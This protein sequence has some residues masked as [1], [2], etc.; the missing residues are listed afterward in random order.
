MYNRADNGLAFSVPLTKDEWSAFTPPKLAVGERWALL[1]TT[2]RQFAAVLSPYA[3]TRFRPRPADATV[4]ELRGEVEAA[5]DRQ[6]RI[7]LTGR[8]QVDW[9]HDGNEHSMGA[10]TAEGC[11]FL[12]F[13]KPGR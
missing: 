10:A 4:A 5:D 7:R 6:A 9:V 11:F 8:W 12:T 3:D 2:A 1:E 13:A